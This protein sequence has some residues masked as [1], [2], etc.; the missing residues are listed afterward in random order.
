[1]PKK[2]AYSAYPTKK[3]QQNKKL[4]FE[5]RFD[6]VT[7]IPLIIEQHDRIKKSKDYF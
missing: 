5:E 3:Q 6:G 7:T 1:M 2:P 4:T